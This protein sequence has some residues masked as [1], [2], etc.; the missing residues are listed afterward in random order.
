MANT[1]VANLISYTPP[2]VSWTAPEKSRP[3]Q[4][5]PK[6]VN[7]SDVAG[8][9]IDNLS[10]PDTMNDMLDAVETAVP[11]SVIAEA[12]MMSGVSKGVHTLDAGI[13]VMPIIIEMLQSIAVINKTK[14]VIYPDDYD[15]EVTVSNRVVRLAVQK[16]MKK[17]EGVDA[18]EAEQ[19]VSP[20]EPTGLMARKQKEVA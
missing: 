7:I 15:K 11:L 19:E 1:N 17:V 5:P 12:M 9:Y 2:G 18:T 13:L 16:A 4:N 14:F 6:L 8:Y 3:W 10:N 20:A